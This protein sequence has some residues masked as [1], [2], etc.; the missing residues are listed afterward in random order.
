MSD[1]VLKNSVTPTTAP[2][3]EHCTKM[4]L[5]ADPAG[6]ATFVS[7]N[8]LSHLG[9]LERAMAQRVA[10]EVTVGRQPDATVTP[11]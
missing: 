6:S 5:T 9:H 2:H 11:R 3:L 4:S 1:A 10:Q 7:K 8:M